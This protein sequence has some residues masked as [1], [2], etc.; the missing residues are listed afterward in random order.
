MEIRL[1]ERLRKLPPY[2][3][4]EVDMLKQ[5]ARQ[6]GKS[7]I[8]LS[9]GDPD[10]P[11]PGFIVEAMAEAIRDPSSH[12]YPSYDGL[13][14]FRE[15]VAQW[16]NE[17]FGVELDPK[18]EVV[19]LIGSKEG[20]AHLPF[21]LLDPADEVLVPDPGYPVYTQA[22][23]LADAIP[24]PFPLTWEYGFLPKMEALE[25]AAGPKTRLIY[26]NYPNNPTAARAPLGFFEEVA[27]WAKAKGIVIAHDAAYSEV[28]LDSP[29]HS[30][31]QAY[32]AKE[33]G[34]EFYS[35]S[36][37]FSMTGW[38]VGFCVGNA[39]VLKALVQVKSNIDSGVFEAIQRAGIV[40]LRN[41]KQA[42]R[43]IALVYAQRRKQAVGRLKSAGIEVFPSDATFYLWCR[44]PKGSDS[45]AFA[46]RLIEES[47]VVVT[48]GVGFGGM[49]E[50]FFR[51]SL[52]APDEMISTGVE[53]I[54]QAF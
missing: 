30:F 1:S 49:G 18:N 23:I 46:K 26:L 40:A 28:F 19:A 51:I 39:S 10:M 14:E 8:D 16:Y 45:R 50:G 33:V 48:P 5:K 32:G 24:K 53:R 42:S 34:V 37:T 21:A 9:I 36:K 29:T 44:V 25:A 43:A 7:L 4:R 31:L 2:L 15:A 13:T 6:E 47:Q 52:T 20:I 11:T 41:A 22:S 17:R 12:R 38:R 35:L 27:A 3:F 54:V